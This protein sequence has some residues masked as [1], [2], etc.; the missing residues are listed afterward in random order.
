MD[1]T[2]NLLLGAN[3]H[4]SIELCN[5]YSPCGYTVAISFTLQINVWDR[6]ELY[7]AELRGEPN[8]C[9]LLSGVDFTVAHHLP[10]FLAAIILHCIQIKLPFSIQKVLQYTEA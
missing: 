4:P 2:T 6:V 1:S 9:I 7:R 8:K 3:I 10:F 5:L